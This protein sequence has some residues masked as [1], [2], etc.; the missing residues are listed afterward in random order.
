MYR[1]MK[2][3]EVKEVRGLSRGFIGESQRLP[4]HQTVITGGKEGQGLA[5][6]LHSLPRRLGADDDVNGI[7]SAAH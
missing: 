7:G 2:Q 1:K 6:Q 5:H 3:L 4:R